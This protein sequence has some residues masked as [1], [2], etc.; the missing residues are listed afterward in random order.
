[1]RQLR[2]IIHIDDDPILRMMVQR[3]IER[4]NHGLE[5]ISCSI[6]QEMMDQLPVFKPDI[7][8]IDVSMPVLNGPDLLRKIRSLR[9][10]TPAIFMTGHE[11]LILEDQEMLEPILGI[12]PKPFVPA[13][14]GHSLVEMW[15]DFIDNQGE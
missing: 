15:N 11:K 2:K 13:E 4:S 8:L 7:L 6:A 9:D 14:L 5:I 12:I 3:S 1:M 10:R